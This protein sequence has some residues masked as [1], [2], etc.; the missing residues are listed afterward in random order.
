MKA[1]LSLLVLLALSA[2]DDKSTTDSADPGADGTDGADG[3]GGAD[4]TSGADGTDGTTTFEEGYAFTSALSGE[5]SVAYSGQVFRNLLIDD[6]KTRIGGLTDR[7]NE[8]AFFPVL[9]DVE[10]ELLF[11]FEF[12][13]SAYGMVEHDKTVA[14]E[15]LQTTYDD[16]SSDKDLVG[17]IAGNDPVGQHVDWSTGFVGWDEGDVS[18]PEDLVRFWIDRIDV[19]AADWSNG[20]IPTDPSGAPVPAVYVTADGLDLQQLLEKFLRAAVGFSQGADDYLDDDTDG[21]GLLSD[22][23]ALVDGKPY[24]ALEHQWDEGFGYFGAARTYDE[25]TDDEI[26]DLAGRDA[27]GDGYIDLQSEVNWGHSTN[28]AKRDRGAVVATDYTQDAWDGF[29][30]GRQLLADTA[31]TELTPEQ[32]AEL[33]G[34]RDQALMAW[35]KAIAAT[36]VHYINDTLQDMGDIGTADYSFADH[37]KHW[38]E[39]KGFALSLQFNP[40]SPMSDTDFAQMH[41]LMGS[42]PLLS[43]ATQTALD[44]YASQLVQARAL[45]GSAYGFDDANLGDDNGENGW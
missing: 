34:Y 37:A 9:G 17:K 39:M 21:K 2:C 13:S 41:G 28:A 16:V 35:E 20:A 11:Y 5:N 38:G 29:V 23:T 40:R 6:M 33:Q 15:C 10:S 42:R 45:L 18:T 27:N 1:H 26:A 44:G 7:I 4:G 22:H 43:D 36:V 8:G 31:G 30:A 25:W 12:D 3:T 14:G 19:Q 32:F 24:T